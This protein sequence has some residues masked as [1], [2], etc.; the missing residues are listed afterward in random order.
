MPYVTEEDK[1]VVSAPIKEMLTKVIQEESGD[2][3]VKTED[4]G[5]QSSKRARISGIFFSPG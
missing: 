2:V 3:S 1:N 5:T 4:E